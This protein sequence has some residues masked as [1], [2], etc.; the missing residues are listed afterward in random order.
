MGL[1]K[2]IAAFLQYGSPYLLNEGLWRIDIVVPRGKAWSL[3]QEAGK[4]SQ[5]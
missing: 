4:L 3:S 1:W 5:S 2:I